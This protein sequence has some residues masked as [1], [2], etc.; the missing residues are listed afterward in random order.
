M[1]LVATARLPSELE[2]GCG[3]Y[4]GSD[5]YEDENRCDQMIPTSLRTFR[6]LAG[7]GTA[8]GRSKADF[9]SSTVCGL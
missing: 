4:F 9:S 6:Y 2:M 5:V 1:W 3:S 8:S 7:N